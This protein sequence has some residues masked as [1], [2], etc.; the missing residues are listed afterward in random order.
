M[1]AEIIAGTV[2]VLWT[3]VALVVLAAAIL[4][5]RLNPELVEIYLSEGQL[6]VAIMALAAMAIAAILGRPEVAR[7]FEVL[8]PGW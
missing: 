4:F 7:E 5:A 1:P 3:L 6:L 2:P 8:V